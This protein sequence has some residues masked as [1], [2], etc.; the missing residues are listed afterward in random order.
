MFSL[1][2]KKRDNYYIFIIISLTQVEVAG[3][4]QHPRCPDRR[5][6]RVSNDESEGLR[7]FG[8]SGFHID[9]M[10]ME[11]PNSHSIYH[12]IEVPTKGT[13]GRPSQN[14]F[15]FIFVLTILQ[16]RSAKKSLG[17]FLKSWHWLI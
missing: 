9:G 10:F 16:K 3:F 5:V 14:I 8:V 13:T 7:D 17:F 12:I 4:E 6:L 2:N 15:T 1:E 11:K